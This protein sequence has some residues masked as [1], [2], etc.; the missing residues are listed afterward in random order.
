MDSLLTWRLTKYDKRHCRL[1][2]D[3]VFYCHSYNCSVPVGMRKQQRLVKRR[4][5]RPW[6][7]HQVCASLFLGRCGACRKRP[8]QLQTLDINIHPNNLRSN[9]SKC[10]TIKYLTFEPWN[11]DAIKS[12]FNDNYKIATRPDG[13]VYHVGNVGVFE[14]VWQAWT[15][16]TTPGR[17]ASLRQ[18][19]QLL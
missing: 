10:R 7:S 13:V 1:P 4:S 17:S 6:H 16:V 15:D 18:V 2:H 9:H 8:H 19:T 5:I 11:C 14:S 12:T 3:T